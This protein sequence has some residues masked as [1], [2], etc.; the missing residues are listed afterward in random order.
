MR[1]GTA[2]AEKMKEKPSEN[3]KAAL[4][5]FNAASDVFTTCRHCRER[6]SASNVS[7]TWKIVNHECLVNGQ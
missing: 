2:Y 5:A 6:V 1:T 7:G 4:A 3:A